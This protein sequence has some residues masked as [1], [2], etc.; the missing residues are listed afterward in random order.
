MHAQARRDPVVRR[1]A[2]SLPNWPVGER[3]VRLL[4]WSDL[5]L[6]DRATDRARLERLVAQ[7]N[8]LR[9]DLVV[10]AG[11]YIAGHEPRDA[12]VAPGLSALSGLRAPLGTVA[13]LGNHEYWTDAPRVR[14][15]LEGAGVTVLA[16][17]AVRRGPLAVGGIDDMVNRREDVVATAA[18][19]R[20][21]GGAPLAVSHSPDVAPRLPAGLPLLLAGHTHCGQIVLPGWGPPVEVSAPRYRCGLVREGGRL[22]VVTAG[23]GT[24]VL[25]LRF[26]APPDWWLLTL[27]G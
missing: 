27:G 18:A 9:P 15:A 14:R 3:T 13:V 4:L 20:E 17:R 5:H 2:V 1:A 16:N 7:A 23:T 26:G 10:L 11:D 19:M 12:L 22:T 25:P 8:A 21:V 6:G 24:S